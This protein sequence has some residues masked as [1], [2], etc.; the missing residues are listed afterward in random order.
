VLAGRIAPGALTASSLL[1]GV[2]AGTAAAAGSRWI[3][4]VLWLAG[5]VLDGLDGALARAT[6]RA[7]DLGGYLD[8]LADTVGY[9]AVPLGVAFPQAETTR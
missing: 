9:A 4:L 6:Q 7:G 3:A 5:R 2:G 1:C 8:L